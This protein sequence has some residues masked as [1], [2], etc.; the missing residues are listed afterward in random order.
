M[1]FWKLLLLNHQCFQSLY[2]HLLCRGNLIVFP[3][4]YLKSACFGRIFARWSRVAVEFRHRLPIFLNLLRHLRLYLLFQFSCCF[5][6]ILLVRNFVFG[7]CKLVKI[8]L[9]CHLML[10]SFKF[11]MIFS[12]LNLIISIN[13]I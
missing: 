5:I 13:S 11:W 2:C 10:S 7:D 12:D 3:F 8:Y 6:V 4:C 9:L 1:R